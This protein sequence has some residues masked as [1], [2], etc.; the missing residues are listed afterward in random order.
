MEAELTL[1]VARLAELHASANGC[2]D[3]VPAE[4]LTETE[5]RLE[6]CLQS[7][8]PRRANDDEVRLMGSRIDALS[9]ALETRFAQQQEK[10]D[11]SKI[12]IMGT[13]P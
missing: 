6:R 5:L 13:V 12:R 8:G 9:K 10:P 1:L 7:N 4:F 2:L 11:E 3:V